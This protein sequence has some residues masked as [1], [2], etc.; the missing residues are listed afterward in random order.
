MRLF[1]DQ[2]LSWRL[3]RALEDLYPKAIH[4]RDVGLATADD[5]LVWTYA[6]SNDLTI[7]TKDAD[8]HQRSFLLGAP[9]RVIWIR[10]GNCSTDEIIQILRQRRGAIEAFGRDSE[11]AFLVLA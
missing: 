7:V 8:F 11:G 1:F 5:A 6:R 10:R 4:V 2:N 9:P 3:G